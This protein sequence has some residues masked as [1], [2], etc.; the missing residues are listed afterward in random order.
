MMKFIDNFFNARKQRKLANKI[1]DLQEQAMIYQR[2]GNLRGLAYVVE[3][4]DNL[5]KEM[6]DNETNSNEEGA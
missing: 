6:S 4:I 3:Q 1:A 2:N 5:E